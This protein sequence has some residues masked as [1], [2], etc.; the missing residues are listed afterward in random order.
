MI[1]DFGL[2]LIKARK[3]AGY[4]QEQA[5]E[6]LDI[7]VRT[8]AKYEANQ[9]KPT[10]DKMNDIVEIYGSEYIGYQYLLTYKLGQKLL[11]PIESKSFSE[12]V[13]S[14]ITNI[15]KSNKC[16]DDLIEIGAD[17][18]V[19]KKEQPKYKQ[20][21]NAFRLMTKD[22]LILKFCKNKKA[23]PFNKQSSI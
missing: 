10:I 21:L 4:T 17:G 13:L 16:I 8:L 12:T 5:S 11:A 1:K 23:E 7:S 9:V 6:L 14:F 19:D 22:I 2:L 3:S 15:K 20:I 18:K